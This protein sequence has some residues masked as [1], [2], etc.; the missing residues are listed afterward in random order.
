V[1]T[2]AFR[3]GAGPARRSTVRAFVS[4]RFLQ[5]GSDDAVRNRVTGGVHSGTAIARISRPTKP[6]PLHANLCKTS[7]SRVC[8]KLHRSLGSQNTSILKATAA[9]F[10]Q[11][12]ESALTNGDSLRSVD[13]SSLPQL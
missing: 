9:R 7:D 5:K 2:C 6:P 1:Q 10:V 11:F 13:E 8:G 12:A 3:S 4:S